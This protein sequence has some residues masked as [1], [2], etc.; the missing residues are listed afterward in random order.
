MNS[1]I[2]EVE[3]VILDTDL[4]P[5]LLMEAKSKG[6]N[7]YVFRKEDFKDIYEVKSEDLGIALLAQNEDNAKY[8]LKNLRRCYLF[9]FNKNQEENGSN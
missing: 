2:N 6:L 7:V 1:E 3:D 9:R 8:N 4:L 5:L